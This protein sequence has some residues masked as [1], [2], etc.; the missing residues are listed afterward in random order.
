[1]A[2]LLMVVATNC[3][4]LMERLSRDCLASRCLE[5]VERSADQASLLTKRLLSQGLGMPVSCGD[6]PDR[7]SEPDRRGTS[8]AWLSSNLE[9]MLTIIHGYCGVLLPIF[10]EGDAR[11]ADVVQMLKAAKR[12]HALSCLLPAVAQGGEAQSEALD[13]N[14]L[15]AD[16]EGIVRQLLGE[17]IELVI[18]LA[19]ELA[20]IQG[21]P[22]Q[23]ERIILNL[24]TNA[25]DAMRGEGRLTIRTTA[26]EYLLDSGQCRHCARLSISDTGCGMDDS[27]LSSAFV[28]C[29]TTKETGKGTGLG[30]SIVREIVYRNHGQIHVRSRPGLGTTFV[31]YLPLASCGPKTQK[32]DHL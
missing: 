17:G 7:S 31:I 15:V 16:I 9:A 20:C 23:I 5:G 8:E 10:P 28:P 25:R 19:P 1:M 12:A 22:T 4:L 32:E 18:E 27:T 11:H 13:L 6:Q 14:A 3:A 21:N 26:T 2:N 30:L 29:F 24:A